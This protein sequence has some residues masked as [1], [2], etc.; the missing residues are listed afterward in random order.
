ML[1]P[2]PG[3]SGDRGYFVRWAHLLTEQP[4]DRAYDPGRWQPDHLPPDLL[5]HWI[6][7]SFYKAIGGLDFDSP[8]YGALVKVLPNAADVLLAVLILVYVAATRGRAAGVLGAGLVLL[9]PPLILTSGVWGQWDSQALLLLAVS[10]FA[11][12]RWPRV[13]GLFLPAAVYAVF[14]KPPLAVIALPVILVPLVRTARR[15]RAEAEGPGRWVPVRRFLTHLF[16]GAALGLVLVGLVSAPFNVSLIKVTG[17]H[18]FLD[19]VAMAGN[20]YQYRAM[21]SPNL[22]GLLQHPMERIPDTDPLALG[23]SAS[24]WGLLL[25]LAFAAAVAV[26]AF[27]RHRTPVFRSDA[28]FGLWCA[29]A[30]LWGSTFFLTRVHERYVL[31]EVVVTL[32][33]ALLVQRRTAWVIFVCASLSS[34]ICTVSGLL[35]ANRLVMNQQVWV[36]GCVA[37]LI[38]GILLMALPFL[39]QPARQA[40]VTG[41]RA[42]LHREGL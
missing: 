26:V 14:I 24:A 36:L 35:Q 2:L 4:L 22:W 10:G 23:L 30:L 21:N 29:A 40:T 1:L 3:H 18:F 15:A 38:V 16:G 27:I 41:A 11:A 8:S 31:P 37:Y 34:T 20:K 7:A 32:V 12:W 33:L 17:S 28:A 25:F 39:R 42:M 5:T 19:L 6:L 9:S 13:G